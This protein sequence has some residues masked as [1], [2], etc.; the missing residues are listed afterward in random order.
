MNL[1][2]CAPMCLRSILGLC[3]GKA[4]F[5]VDRGPALR[6]PAVSSVMGKLLSLHGE[7]VPKAR[8]GAHAPNPPR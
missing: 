3:Q 1:A 5:Q 2:K 6:A 8:F 7:Y 4:R